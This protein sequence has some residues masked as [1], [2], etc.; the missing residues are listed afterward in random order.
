MTL[1]FKNSNTLTMLKTQTSVSFTRGELRRQKILE[2]AETLFLEK[3]YAGTSVNQVVKSAGGSLNT[4]YRYFDNKLGLFEAVFRKKTDEIFSP[5][6][7]CDYWQD[8]IETNLTNFG[9]ALQKV[10]LSADGVAI[11]RLVVSEN[12]EE[13]AQIHRIFLEHGPQK[14]IQILAKYLDYEQQKGKIHVGNSQL[15]AAQLLEMIKGP[16][17]YRMMFGQQISPVEIEQALK[18]GVALFLKGVKI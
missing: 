5:F 14:A 3:G 4:L 15:A 17:Y 18:Q 10:V 8:D 1:K 12:N 9:R 11:N 16:F 6:L 7:N 2:V 13:Q